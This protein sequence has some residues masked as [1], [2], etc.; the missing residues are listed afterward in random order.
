MSYSALKFYRVYFYEKGRLTH[1]K[2]EARSE[3]DAREFVKRT[4]GYE[5]VVEIYPLED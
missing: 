5:D 2:V 3:E 4:P 1:R